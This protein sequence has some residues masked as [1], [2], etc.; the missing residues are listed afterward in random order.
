MRS[1]KA[2]SVTHLLTFSTLA[3]I[4]VVSARDVFQS[5]RSSYHFTSG[6]SGRRDI[7]FNNNDRSTDLKF[8]ESI[9]REEYVDSQLETSKEKF[10]S[11]SEVNSVQWHFQVRR[12]RS[13]VE[14]DLLESTT[15]R[16]VETPNVESDIIKDGKTV[17]C[18]RNFSVHNFN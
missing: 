2:P 11:E 15:G 17:I 12:K 4:C 3:V 16:T 1:I 18:F 5:A 14:I 6:T 10:A 9:S 13:P 7:N 8:R